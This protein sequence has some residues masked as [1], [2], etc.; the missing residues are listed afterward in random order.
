MGEQE[1][2]GPR[3]S[4]EKHEHYWSCGERGFYKGDKREY[5]KSLGRRPKTATTER[6]HPYLGHS[7]GQAQRVQDLGSKMVSNLGQWPWPKPFGEAVEVEPACYV[8]K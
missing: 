7:M 6:E 5:S 1:E 4:C 3:Q 8:L 2:R